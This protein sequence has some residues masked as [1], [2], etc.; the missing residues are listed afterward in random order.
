MPD[1]DS[2]SNVETLVPPQPVETLADSIGEETI[3]G[4]GA[5]PRQVSAASTFD[6]PLKI[7]R[8][9]ILEKLGSGG[10]GVVFAAHDPELDRRIAIKLVHA[11]EGHSEAERTASRGR[12]KREAT[13]MAKLSHPN[14]VTV[15]DVGEHGG[16]LYIAMELIEGT[17]LRG[18]ME[19]MPRPTVA[20]IVGVFALA[21][22]G[23]AAAHHAGLVHRDFKP[24]NV[25]VGDTDEPGRAFGEV[26]VLDFGLASAVGE[27]LEVSDEKASAIDVTAVRMTATGAVM[28]TPAYMSPEQMHGEAADARSDQFSFCV[29]LFEALYGER[30]F[31]GAGLFDL[32]HAVTSGEIEMPRDD[33]GVPRR[34]RQSVMRGLA[35]RPEDRHASMDALLAALVPSRRLPRALAGGAA[36]VLLAGA[37][38]VA[39]TDRESDVCTGARDQMQDVWEDHR[40]SIRTAFIDTGLPYAERAW[41]Q[42]DARLAEWTGAWAESHTEACLATRVREERS[43]DILDE[44]MRCLAAAKK[45]ARALTRLFAAADPGLV[46]RAE[47]A[48]RVLS[49]PRACIDLERLHRGAAVP[50]DP[51]SAARVEALRARLFEARGH[52]LRGEPNPA[53][54]ILDDV[55]AQAQALGFEPFIAEVAALRGELQQSLGAYEDAV[56]SFEKAHHLALGLGHDELARDAAVSLAVVTGVQMARDDDAQRWIDVALA[57]LRRTAPEPSDEGRI[58]MGIASVRASQGQLEEAEALAREA[59]ALFRS[60]YGDDDPRVNEARATLGE[61]LLDRRQDDAA[62]EVF[63]RVLADAQSFG[64]GHPAEARAR[65][66]LGRVHMYRGDPASGQIEFERAI[67]IL[68]GTYGDAHPELATALTLLGGSM[69]EQARLEEA[70]GAHHR[71]IEIVRA[72]HGPGHAEL[73]RI[74]DNLANVKVAQGDHASAIE[75]YDEAITILEQTRGP[76]H[77]AVVT[78]LSNKAN[79]FLM[80]DRPAD[81]EPVFER[82]LAIAEAT[83]GLDALPIAFSLTGLGQ[84]RAIAGR[85]AE[86]LPAFERA[87]KIREGHEVAPNLMGSTRYSVA[88][89]LIETGGDRHR[90]IELAKR[91]REDYRA[92]PRSEHAALKSIDAFLADVDR[93]PSS[94]SVRTRYSRPWIR[95]ATERAAVIPWPPGVAQYSSLGPLESLNTHP[96][97]PWSRSILIPWPPGAVLRRPLAVRRADRCA[98]STRRCACPCPGDAGSTL[99][100]ALRARARNGR[101]WRGIREASRSRREA[102]GA[103]WR[104]P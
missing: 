11:S 12:M 90:A 97:A 28:G 104:G 99:G 44:E 80:M 19:R 57:M 76:E 75:M 85:P 50:D 74:Y 59:M 23:L 7:G 81:A 38:W 42:A 61:I 10:M 33:P 14:V 95:I 27:K 2:A 47:A 21:G 87:L 39:L 55:A 5:A 16:Q 32:I 96:L 100:S 62:Q 52:D 17:S 68:E 24:D 53:L 72:T 60:A 4:D 73:A 84:A 69:Y 67:A 20:E 79:A 36:A 37:G 77:P 48:T 78:T 101:A 3:A 94:P 89:A 83:Y 13:A 70:A 56:R 22:R 45:E 31:K 46:E 71:A 26:R 51:E 9:E 82:A 41:A 6:I 63:E 92:A 43:T 35:T 1:S 29:A 65:M 15:Y 93:P 54:R 86:A 91:A 30:P 8:H 103:S 98:Q 58:K 25:M 88:I 34:L 49:D 40:E 66:E 18:W 64:N 102:C